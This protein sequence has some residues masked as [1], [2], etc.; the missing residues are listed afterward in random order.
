V[1]GTYVE[2]IEVAILLEDSHAVDEICEIK[3]ALLEGKIKEQCWK[4][5]LSSLSNVPPPGHHNS[6]GLRHSRQRR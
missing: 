1:D 6:P 3:R 4:D 2:G 5:A